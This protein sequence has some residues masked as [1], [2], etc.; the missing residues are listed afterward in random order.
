MSGRNQRSD[1]YFGVFISCFSRLTS[2]FSLLTSLLFLVSSGLLQRAAQE[3]LDLRIEAAQIVVRPALDLLQQ[4]RID[5]KQ[6]GFT[7]RH[8]AY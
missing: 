2:Y 6:E 8:D 1:G 5:T 7:I 4:G 3:E